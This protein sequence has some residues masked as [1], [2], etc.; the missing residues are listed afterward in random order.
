MTKEEIFDNCTISIKDKVGK[1]YYFEKPKGFTCELLKVRYDSYHNI[2]ALVIDE[3]NSS[4]AI[5]YSTTG[6]VHDGREGFEKY[7]LV[8]TDK[9]KFFEQIED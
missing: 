3:Y 5:C 9:T 4:L 6:F 7:T 1:A 8:S 2:I